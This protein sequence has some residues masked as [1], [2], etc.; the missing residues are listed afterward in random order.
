MRFSGSALAILFIF[1]WL[2]NT[3]FAQSG[4][5]LEVFGGFSYLHVDNK[6]GRGATDAWGFQ[7]E[8]AYFINEWFGLSADVSHHRATTD[9]PPE[10]A[11][12]GELTFRNTTFLFGPRF[13]FGLG[14]RFIPTAQVLVGIVD[15]KSEV[16]IQTPGPIPGSS[17][18]MDL[19]PGAASFVRSDLDESSFAVAAGISLDLVISGRFAYR[20]LQ[21]D[22]I[23]TSFGNSTQVDLRLGTGIV[24]RF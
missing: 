9:A 1:M 15:R 6:E 10:L 22:L 2:P 21:P 13:R 18:G 17:T 11:D 23:I 14:E 5:D 7:A 19:L 4:D 8:F 16:G 3:A 12:S 24:V 20:I